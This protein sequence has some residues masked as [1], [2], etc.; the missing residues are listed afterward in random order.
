[1]GLAYQLTPKTVVRSGYGIFYDTMGIDRQHVNQGGFNQ[2]TNLI[3]SL[4]NGLS[5]VATLSNPFPGGLEAPLG[6]AGGLNTFLGRGISFFYEKPLNPYMQRWSLSVQRQFPFRTLMDVAYVGNRGTKI[7]VSRQLNPV[8][9]QYLST[10]P[11]R[12]QATIDFLSARVANPFF[13]IPQFAG[14]ALATNTINRSQLLRERPHFQGISTSFPAGWSYYHSLQLAVEKRSSA[15]LTFQSSWTWSKFMEAINYLNDTDPYL[16]K[17]ISDQDYQHRFTASAIWELP[18]GRGKPLLG[19]V[20]GPLHHI[21]SGWQLQGV[22][23]GQSGPP[24]G[25]G[26][27]IF[28]GNLHDIVLPVGQRSPERWF[29]TGAGFNRNS[30][31]Q[32]ANNIRT[33][34]SRF[35]GIR[36]DGINNFDMSF[37]KTFSIRER[38]RVQFRFE[39]YNTM[40]HVQFE[41]PNTSPVSTAFGTVTDEK[42]HGQRQLNLSLKLLF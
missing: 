32:L 10:L 36:A 34:P 21:V 35:T 23:E 15:G 26:N 20:T 33:F 17:V 14:T 7:D 13:G 41:A 4:D 24:L 42:G 8:P 16:E 22:Y 2:S 3:P 18:F 11:V 38:L 9:R 30:R 29:N 12:D 28:T 37:F 40:N 27:A 31:E 1:M 25:F 19:H 39:T 6:A 5:F